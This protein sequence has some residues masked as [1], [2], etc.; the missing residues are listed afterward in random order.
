MKSAI[1]PL[2]LSTA[3]AD[4]S[5]CA[6]CARFLAPGSSGCRRQFTEKRKNKS[7]FSLWQTKASRRAPISPARRRRRRKQSPCGEARSG[8][9]ASAPPQTWL[10]LTVGRQGASRWMQGPICL[11]HT[12]RAGKRRSRAAHQPAGGRR[13]LRPRR[14]CGCGQRSAGRRRSTTEPKST[15]NFY[16][17]HLFVE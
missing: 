17:A 2:L 11:K 10:L 15:R 5:T 13:D 14:S 12:H 9:A 16:Y 1:I 3:P 8:S 4:R 6:H 7:F